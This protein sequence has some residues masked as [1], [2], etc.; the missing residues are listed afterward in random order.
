MSGNTGAFLATEI[1]IK[2]KSSE[3]R[4]PTLVLAIY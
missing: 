4:E 2:Y 3:G 1:N